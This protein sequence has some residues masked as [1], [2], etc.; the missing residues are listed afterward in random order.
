MI[1]NGWLLLIWGFI[2]SIIAFVF[3]YFFI[4]LKLKPTNQISNLLYL[5][6]ISGIIVL[7]SRKK[8]IK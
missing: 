7:L 5:N 4:Y 6:P 8:I 2:C 3:Q 1:K